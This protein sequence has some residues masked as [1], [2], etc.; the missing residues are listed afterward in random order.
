MPSPGA[1][2]FASDGPTIL[3]RGNRTAFTA[4]ASTGETGIL[5]LDALGLISG[6]AYE[7]Y[8]SQIR[9]DVVTAT[10]RGKFHLRYATSG[11][12]TTA[13]TILR[14]SEGID[15][16]SLGAF[17]AWRFPTAN[18]NGSLLLSALKVS[19]SSV[20]TVPAD[21]GGVDLIVFDWGVAPADTG[22]DI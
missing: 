20:F 6:R 1:V 17:S 16:D 2:V 10:D 4:L 21:E 15:D 5:R 18:E 22:V 9:Y 7:F 12:A 3:R 8:V 11:T 19:G 14:R 13:S